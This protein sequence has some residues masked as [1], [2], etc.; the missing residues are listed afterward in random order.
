MGS[1]ASWWRRRAGVVAFVSV[2]VT[3]TACASGPSGAGVSPKETTGNSAWDAI[4]A[5]ANQEGTVTLYLSTPGV[6]DAVKAAFSKS[7]PGIEFK[8]FRASTGDM[9]ARLDQE[10]ATNTAGVDVMVVSD[11]PWFEA[12]KGHF[13]LPK[14]PAFQKYWKGTDYSHAGGLYINPDVAPLGIAYNPDLIKSLGAKPIKTY[15]DV[16]QPE[17]AK[18]LIAIQPATFSATNAKYWFGVAQHMGSD[19][20]KKLADLGPVPYDS[21]SPAVQAV[22]SG[23]HAVSIY[24]VLAP[25]QALIDKGAPV[26]WINPD[27]AIGT[28]HNAA[29]AGWSKHPNAAQVFMNWLMSP[30]G[31]IGLCG[32]GLLYCPL[33]FD[34]LGANVPDTMV[35]LPS[36]ITLLPDEVSTETSD[37][38]N[39]TWKPAIGG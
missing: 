25:A 10:I 37:W 39:K 11:A 16:L 34:Q 17:F 6:E 2:V 32:N 27:P 23:E 14:G 21:S 30:A 13:A 33:T 29:I 35:E 1:K 36:N 18:G 15:A 26:K 5:K 9:Q 4:V 28:V 3:L 12:N 8:L 22:A 20:I 19:A 38:V 31:Q 7:Y 24:Q